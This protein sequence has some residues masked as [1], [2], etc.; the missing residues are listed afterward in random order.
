MSSEATSYCLSKL[1]LN[2][3]TIILAKM[4][5]ADGIAVNSVCPGWVRTDMAAAEATR[6]VEQ[7]A[8]GIVWLAAEAD[9][10]PREVLSRREVIPW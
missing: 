2:G 3:A 5:A 10:A 7:G 1:A 8:A 6:S 4:L 9:Q